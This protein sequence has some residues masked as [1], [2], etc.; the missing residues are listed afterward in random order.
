MG[1]DGLAIY[2]GADINV[3]KEQYEKLGLKVKLFKISSPFD[4]EFCSYRFK[5]G[6]AEPL[7][8]IKMVVRFLHNVNPGAEICAQ[9]KQELRHSPNYTK[10]KGYILEAWPELDK[11]L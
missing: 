1:D 9:F 8:W 5:D 4:F 3:I 11:F 6:V 10:A 2:R 7:N